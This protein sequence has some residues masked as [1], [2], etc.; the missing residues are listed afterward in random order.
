MSP[1]TLY[2]NLQICCFPVLDL[3]HKSF[4][5]QTLLEFRNEK[6]GFWFACMILKSYFLDLEN[7][8]TDQK[9]GHLV[10]QKNPIHA[11]TPK[12]Q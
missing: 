11:M 1:V 4:L 3:L 5:H 6:C 7:R 9:M 8:Y 10:Q 12:L 2:L